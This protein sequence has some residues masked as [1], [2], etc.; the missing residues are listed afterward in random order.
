MQLLFLLVFVIILSISAVSCQQKKWE[1]RTLTPPRI[2][3]QKEPL[4]KPNDSSQR[5]DDSLILP[6][7]FVRAKDSRWVPHFVE[8]GKQVGTGSEYF[9]YERYGVI[10]TPME[11]GDRI[12]VI[13]RVRT[14]TD[15][16]VITANDSVA[17]TVDEMEASFD[18]LVEDYLITS[19][20]TGPGPVGI[21]VYY[22]LT[23]QKVCQGVYS[24]DESEWDGYFITL[25]EPSDSIATAENCP[26]Y[27]SWMS[28]G[29][30]P[31]LE[32]RITLDIRSCTKTRLRMFRCIPYQ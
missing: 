11:I 19:S 12:D 17:F 3:V 25:W 24:D 26:E 2:E 32:E 31:T 7:T 4:P 23:G 14:V 10:T 9:A 8:V 30:S 20:S 1:P 13:K 15:T 29:L 27:N 28:K 22:L 21:D 6:K 5:K 18:G 16:V